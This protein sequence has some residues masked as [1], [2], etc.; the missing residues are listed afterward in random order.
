MEQVSFLLVEQGSAERSTADDP[1]VPLPKWLAS[2]DPGLFTHRVY[3][4]YSW[5][6]AYELVRLGWKIDGAIWSTRLP[7]KDGWIITLSKRLASEPS[8]G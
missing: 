8:N 3:T 5:D 2:R 4:A 6:R 7:D 1:S